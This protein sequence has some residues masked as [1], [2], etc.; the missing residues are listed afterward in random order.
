[1]S[2]DL[3]PSA[4][5]VLRYWFGS[6]ADDLEV[7]EQQSRL[8]W[9]HEASTDKEIRERFAELLE[10]AGR[11]ELDGWCASPRG[12]LAVIVV[13]DQFSRNV[14]R[15]SAQAFAQDPC[16]LALCVE[17]LERD[18]D[19]ALRPIERLFFY[20]PLE[21]AESLALQE[22]SVAEQRDLLAEV[23]PAWRDTFAGFVDFALR[24]REVIA[25]FGRFPHRNRLLGRESTP[26]E[27]TFLAQP[28]SAF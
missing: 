8:W 19:H 1:M 13:L 22:R 11:G 27:L 4:T 23:P 15:G 17:G 16:A 7:N 25:R 18:E 9:G 14:H 3:D 24:H 26:E 28:G 12:R 6:S 21:H 10:R 2:E 20:L 5:E